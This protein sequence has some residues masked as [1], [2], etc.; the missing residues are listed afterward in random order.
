M[1]IRIHKKLFCGCVVRFC[2]EMVNNH[3]VKREGE[4]L[5]A[6]NKRSKKSKFKTQNFFKSVEK[7]TEIFEY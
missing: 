1:F 5:N 7:K 4:V 6:N 2:I 3:E